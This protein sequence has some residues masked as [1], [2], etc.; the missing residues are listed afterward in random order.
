VS[1]VDRL[2]GMVAF[3]SVDQLVEQMDA[4]VDRA[5]EILAA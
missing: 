5:R 2:R 4:D 1:F 3:E